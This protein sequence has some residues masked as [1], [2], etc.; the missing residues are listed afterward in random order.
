MESL[1][2]L[3]FLLLRRHFGLWRNASFKWGHQFLRKLISFFPLFVDG[4]RFDVGFSVGLV[5]FSKLCQLFRLKVCDCRYCAINLGIKSA[6]AEI[7][8]SAW[9]QGAPLQIFCHQT[10]SKLLHCKYF[11]IRPWTRSSIAQFLQSDLIYLIYPC[12]IKQKKLATFLVASWFCFILTFWT[13]LWRCC[14][15]SLIGFVLTLLPLQILP[16]LQLPQL[17]QLLFPIVRGVRSWRLCSFGR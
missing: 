12:H 6:I 8:P 2:R 15:G 13:C 14:L 5:V 11:T 9:S 4:C 1:A 10:M 16:L 3:L 17:L 7:L